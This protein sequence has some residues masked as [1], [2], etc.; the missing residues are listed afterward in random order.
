MTRDL[1]V[2]AVALA[3]IGALGVVQ[4]LRRAHQRLARDLERVHALY[5]PRPVPPPRAP[6]KHDTQT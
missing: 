3:G 6:V 1:V 4:A 5:G 2:A